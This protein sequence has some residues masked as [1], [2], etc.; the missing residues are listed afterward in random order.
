MSLCTNVQ[1]TELTHRL[2]L[3]LAF[4]D[5]VQWKV[6][7]QLYAYLHQAGYDLWPLTGTQS[8]RVV[9]CSLRLHSKLWA[10]TVY[11]RRDSDLLQSD[12]WPVR[13][14]EVWGCVKCES[15]EVCTMRDVCL[16]KAVSLPQFWGGQRGFAPLLGQGWMLVQPFYFCV[17]AFWFLYMYMYVYVAS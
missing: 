6:V 11:L 1:Y 12:N 13:V 15:E 8:S 9:I 16:V 3:Q 2:P 14:C 5:V 7:E 4:S 17:E 10:H